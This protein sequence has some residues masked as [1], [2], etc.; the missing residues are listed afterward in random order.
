MQLNYKRA[1]A[2][3]D[4]GNI[5]SPLI[6]SLSSIANPF[7]G[8]MGLGARASQYA[9]EEGHKGYEAKVTGAVMDTGTTVVGGAQ[10]ILALESLPRD[11]SSPQ[12]L[13]VEGAKLAVGLYYLIRGVAGY[14]FLVR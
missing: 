8:L 4:I 12:G 2:L 13:M 1:E 5:A 10:T 7:A 14:R 6:S 9:V 3:F 11:A